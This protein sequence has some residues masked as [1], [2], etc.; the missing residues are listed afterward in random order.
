MAARDYYRRSKAMV[1]TNSK[2]SQQAEKLAR[3]NGVE[4]WGRDKLIKELNVRS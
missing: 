3:K 1:V 2:F 4:L